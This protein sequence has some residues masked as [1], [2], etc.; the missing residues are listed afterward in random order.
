MKKY[1]IAAVFAAFI[2][3]VIGIYYVQAAGERNPQFR[4][5]ATEG[6]AKEADSLVLWGWYT[7]APYSERVKVS[8]SGSRY[9][10]EL[11]YFGRMKEEFIHN[12]PPIDR[13]VRQYPDFMREDRTADYQDDELLVRVKSDPWFQ[14]DKADATRGLAFDFL[15]K[16]TKRTRS[17]RADLPE[18][19][20]FNG[21]GV[22]DVQ[23]SGDSFKV[24]MYYENLRAGGTRGTPEIRIYDV[25]P[26]N[27]GITGSVTVDSGLQPAD[28]QELILREVQS[29]DWTLPSGYLVLDASLMEVRKIDETESANGVRASAAGQVEVERRLVVYRYDTGTVDVVTLPVEPL[30]EQTR[31]SLYRVGAEVLRIRLSSESAVIQGYGLGDMK[32]HYEKT[33]S[34]RD[35]QAESIT[36]SVA[37]PNR[38]YLLLQEQDRPAVAAMD[39]EGGNIVFRGEAALDDAEEGKSASP[40]LNNLR[41]YSL[42]MRE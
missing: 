27:G 23:R 10:G 14:A 29:Y 2:V 37:G 22:I 42:Y 4:L 1:A 6:D 26:E 9:Y 38:L 41:L 13:L 35:L 24:A 20:A 30:N 3:L 40:L 34:A 8:A 32:L 21:Y 18:N 16:R 5:V 12:V 31:E 11:S 36:Q 7:D 28:G 17:L 33:L 19:A 15:D 39:P 25:N